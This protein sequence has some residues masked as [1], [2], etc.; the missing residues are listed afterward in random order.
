MSTLQ[1]EQKIRQL[2]GYLLPEIMD[3]V[4]F[5]LN[6]HVQPKQQTKVRAFT[7]DW[8]GGLSNLSDKFTSVE[9]QHKVLEWRS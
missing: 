2:P 1:I 9:L 3:Y 7:F 5:L 4:D 6:K 8:E